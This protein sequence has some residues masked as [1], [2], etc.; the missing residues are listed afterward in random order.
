GS[1]LAVALLGVTVALTLACVPLYAVLVERQR[2]AGAADAAALAAA[3]V[4]VGRH[5]GIP[6]LVARE[7]ATANRTELEECV[8]DGLIVMV[9]ATG[10]VGVFSVSVDATAGPPAARP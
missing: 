3:D 5:P 6:C 8:V 9:R 1:V 4:A 2:V 10:R 7:L